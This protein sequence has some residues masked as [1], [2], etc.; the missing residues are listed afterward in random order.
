MSALEEGEKK[1]ELALIII[2]STAKR[3]IENKKLEDD[4]IKATGRAIGWI[5]LVTAGTEYDVF[6]TLNGAIAEAVEY[7]KSNKPSNIITS[8]TRS[9]VTAG[10]HKKFGGNEEEAKSKKRKVAVVSILLLGALAIIFGISQFSAVNNAQSFNETLRNEAQ[11]EINDVC[12]DIVEFTELPPAPATWM[13]IFGTQAKK[14]LEWQS[15]QNK[16]Q[17]KQERCRD[18]KLRLEKQVD[19]SDKALATTYA[20]IPT[21]VNSLLTVV[22]FIGTGTGIESLPFVTQVGTALTQFT[23]SV[24]TG[25]LPNAAEMGSFVKTIGAGFDTPSSTAPAPPPQE[26]GKR[27]QQAP[28]PIEIPP[29]P[30]AATTTAPAATT[31]APAA[32]GIFGNFNTFSNGGRK[33]KK[34]STKKFKKTRRGI[35]KPLFKY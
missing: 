16:A 1:T 2:F 33:T 26:K 13:D 20:N 6:K 8:D 4:Q 19:I 5:A 32:T 17:R 29:A 25:T 18:T 7:N 9:L 31:T 35:R 22:S 10:K 14:I 12:K 21:N 34:R 15:R 11:D 30:P 24:T 28:P 3:I 27:G 23:K